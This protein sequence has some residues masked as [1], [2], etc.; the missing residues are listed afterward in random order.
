MRRGCCAALITQ[1]DDRGFGP[2]FESCIIIRYLS[3]NEAN[4]FLRAHPRFPSRLDLD[5]SVSILA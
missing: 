1:I 4:I 2:S 5:L 3:N